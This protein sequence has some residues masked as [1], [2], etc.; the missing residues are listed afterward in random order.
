VT[1][2]RFAVVAAVALG[3]LVLPAA[4]AWAHPLG[5]FTINT[6]SSLIVRADEVAIAYVIDMAEIPAFREQRTIDADADGTADATETAAYAAAACRTAAAG[7]DVTVDGT[8]ARVIDRGDASLTFPAGAGGLSTLRLECR[9]AAP[10]SDALAIGTSVDV[11]FADRNHADALGWREV[12]AVGDGVTLVRSDVPASSETEVLRSYPR[13]DLPLDV[14]TASLRVRGGGPRLV[15][16]GTSTTSAVPPVADGGILASLVGR[17]DVTPPLVGLMVLVALGVGALHA[18]GPGHGKT[19]IGAYLVGGGGTIRHA[20]GVGAAVSVMH[21]ASVLA[22]GGVVL[23]AERVVAP[24]RVYPWL[25]VAAGA[26]AIVLGTFLLRSR[27]AGFQSTHDHDDQWTRD[28]DDRHN[29]GHEH[30]HM[31]GEGDADGDGVISSRGLVALAFSGGALPSPTALVVFLGAVSLGRAALGLTLIAA[32]SLGLAAAL[33]GVGVVALR[34]RSAAERRIS[35]RVMRFV[36]VAS[37]AAIV[38]MGLFLAARGAT[39]L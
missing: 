13:E 19:L 9:L 21:T 25:G 34:A 10:L 24:E 15:V 4:A 8:P 18:L 7:L 11:R 30:G 32:F 38:A 29:H 23:A 28:H 31:H 1:F 36:P 26:I 5:N 35:P 37:A 2:R 14:R 17:A 39:Q 22:L 20:V 3:V 12:S 27:L 6:S 33:I 16:D